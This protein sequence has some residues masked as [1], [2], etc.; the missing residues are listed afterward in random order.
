MQ[1]EEIRQKKEEFHALVCAETERRREFL[2]YS[3]DPRLHEYFAG[4][5]GNMET[6][7]VYE[8]A[9]AVKFLRLCDTYALNVGRAQKFVKFY[10]SLK[11]NGM[12]GRRQYRMTPIQVFQFVSIFLF[13]RPDFSRLVRNVILFVPRKFGK[14]TSVASLGVYEFLFGDSNAEAYMAANSSSQSGRCYNEA[15]GLLA[16]LDPKKKFLRITQNEVTW[17]TNQMG[18]ESILVRLTAGASTKDGLNA[19]LVV[20]DEFAAAHYV[21]DRSDGAELYNVLTSSMGTRREPLAVIIT[22]ASR[23][24][25]SPF[26]EILHRAQ[27]DLLTENPENDR[28]FAS[29]F[30][31]DPWMTHED[32][33]HPDTWAMCN[34]HI[35]ITVQPNFYAEEWAEA[36][37]NQEKMREYLCKYLNVFLSGNVK[38]W[39]PA[40]TIRRHAIPQCVEEVADAHP[41]AR[42]ISALDFSKGDDLNCIVYMVC[43]DD[44][45]RDA[46]SNK[47]FL[48]FIDCDAWISEKTLSEHPNRGMYEKWVEDGWL[49]VS[50]GAVID[51]RL[52][53]QRVGEVCEHLPMVRIGFDPYDS[54]RYV[55]GLTELCVSMGGS[56]KKIIRPVSQTWGSFNAATQ[57]FAHLVNM[58]DGCPLAFSANPILPWCF[59]NC[60]LEEDRMECVKPVKKS[61]GQK[62]DAAICTLMCIKLLDEIG[63][64]G[65]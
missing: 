55:V 18:K 30:C 2:R 16:Q 21:K 48:Y 19:S 23:V 5:C 43:L 40:E 26:E 58:G 38:D 34:P 56:P 62:I 20:Y 8:Y 6:H 50:P 46:S 28:E 14:T 59:G 32:Y 45:A 10:E 12:D 65:L 51:E 61:A 42:C 1:I 13:D 57:A 39:I 31:P 44:W 15:K 49:R 24:K 64:K 52:V 54:S 3:V 36:L 7:N 17:Y 25:L 22:T 27:D 47:E 63:I 37:R 29:I 9:A 11:F 53:V 35:G 41:G 33:G 4:L 60:Y